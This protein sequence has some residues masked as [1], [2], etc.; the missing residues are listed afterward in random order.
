VAA[1]E[2]QQ[3]R[4][5]GTAEQLGE[6]RAK[7]LEMYRDL[8]DLLLEERLPEEAFGVLES[9]R[10]RSLLAMLAERDIVVRDVPAELERERRLANAEHDRT[11]AALRQLTAADEE[12]RCGCWP[13]S[14]P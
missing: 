7:Y 11:T 2:A 4:L 14:T 6:F 3:R 8:V 5:G 13:R 12:E 9:A 1:L 10:A